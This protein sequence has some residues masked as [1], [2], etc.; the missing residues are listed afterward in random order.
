MNLDRINKLLDKKDYTK[1]RDIFKEVDEVDIAD[2]LDEY[3]A[4]TTLLLFRLLPKEK[5][6]DV[7]AYLSVEQKTQISML[8]SDS[9][10]V[11][12][13]DDLFFDD[14]I[15]YLE[16]M[17]A[18]VVKRILKNASEN[19]RRLINQFLNYPE[20]SAGSLM[21]IEF[22][23]LKKEM[24]I[25]AAMEKIRRI[26]LDRET[27]YTCYIIDSKRRLEGTVSL[28]ELVL[29]PKDSRV[30]DI[31]RQDPI[32]VHTHDDQEFVA[33]IFKRYDLLAVPVVDQE[34]RLVGIITVDDII[35]VID[36]ENTED[37]HKMA[38]LQPTQEEYLELGVIS[39]AK[40]RIAWLLIL[41]IS[42]AF[43]GFIIQKY[44]RALESV[45]ALTVFIPMLMSTGGNAG[46][47]ASTLI[48]RGIALGEIEFK[49]TK[50]ILW[51]ELRVS[52]IVGVGLAIINFLRIYYLEGY[53]S[54][55]ALTVSLTTL[56][57]VVTAKII[58]SVLPV[59]AKLAKVDPAIMAAPLITTIVDTL[60]LI[61]YFQ[62]ATKIM[63]I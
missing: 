63:G 5:A 14:K 6:A 56:A 53:T 62:L 13:I 35:D 12:I 31:M 20:N 54:N 30:D 2:I 42:A 47:Q 48:I 55:I 4:K 40:K 9:E 39:L 24:M 33:D 36:D 11:A 21:T 15:D 57:T 49:N 51:K 10:L 37:F 29:A 17:P 26:G 16:E 18:S 22:V 34:N 44:E 58:G 50:A 8:V 52:L 1:I 7:F 45:V 38:A 61:V 32:A 27:I 23:D 43:T 41:M 25:S 46:S 28:R 59:L 60:T 19:E 3:D